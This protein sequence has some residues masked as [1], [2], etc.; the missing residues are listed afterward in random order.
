MC[1]SATL[2]V[3][4]ESQVRRYTQ[5]RD[6]PQTVDSGKAELSWGD[7][8]CVASYSWRKFCPGNTFLQFRARAAGVSCLAGGGG[9]VANGPVMGSF[10]V[11]GQPLQALS[12]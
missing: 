4:P 10:K 11:S 9:P 7:H 3:S 2:L 12:L 1:A 5:A 6:A 8:R